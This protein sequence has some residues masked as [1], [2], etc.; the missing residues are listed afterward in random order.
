M[1]QPNRDLIDRQDYRGLDEV[2]AEVISLLE[3]S[4]EK[5]EQLAD[6]SQI[7]YIRIA[8]KE[9]LHFKI[10]FQLIDRESRTTEQ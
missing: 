10:M 7:A 5:K 3:L 8:G 4:D 2:R 1:F 6:T 9:S